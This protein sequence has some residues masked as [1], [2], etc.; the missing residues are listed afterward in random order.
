M[1]KQ[2]QNNK[3]KFEG[4]KSKTKEDYDIEIID[5]K[6]YYNCIIKLYLS[7]SI[8]DF[9]IFDKPLKIFKKGEIKNP[10]HKSVF[11]VGFV[12]EGIYKPSENNRDTKEYS[13]WNGMLRRC[14]SKNPK[15]NNPTY[16]D[17]TV[18][19]EW[20]N[21]QNLAKWHKENYNPETMEG[22]QLDK[23]IIC[24]NCK[25]YSPE[26]CAFV[27]KSINNIIKGKGKTCV[28]RKGNRF[29]AY[30]SKENKQYY[31]GSFK[32]EDEAFEA[33]KVEKVKYINE[34]LEPYLG[35]LDKRV[36]KSLRNLQYL[37]ITEKSAQKTELDK[38]F[39]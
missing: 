38:I 21:F 23:D 29:L 32:T 15:D 11:G 13:T 26:T 35:I 12:G 34:K 7:S 8:N 36:V 4:L 17:V 1:S 19:E 18:C 14:Y 22:W 6:G 28:R 3:L 30:L 37:R 24:P 33:Y 10:Y 27:P 25:I 5:Y 9:L 39:I 20:H 2:L 31:V 16:K